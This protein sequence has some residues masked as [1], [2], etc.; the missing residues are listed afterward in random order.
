MKAARKKRI[1]TVHFSVESCDRLSLVRMGEGLPLNVDGSVEEVGL[2]WLVWLGFSKN[3]QKTLVETINSGER[4]LGTFDFCIV[5]Y[6][7]VPEK[8]IEFPSGVLVSRREISGGVSEGV[9]GC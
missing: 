5:R 9:V 4:H 8:W 7:G 6:F 2:F 1:G 3:A